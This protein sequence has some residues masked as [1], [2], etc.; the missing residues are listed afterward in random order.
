MTYQTNKFI[1]RRRSSSQDGVTI[2]LAIL[3]LSS[4]LAIT[5]SL[6]S[7]LFIE[8]RSSTDLVKS[9]GS[10]Y[11]SSAVA[12]EAVYS[13]KRGVCPSDNQNCFDFV[14]NFSSNSTL[15]TQPAFSSTSTPVIQEKIPRYTSFTNTKNIYDF[16]GTLATQ[17]GCG[18]GR[19]QIVFNDI[20]NNSSAFVYLCEFS[21]TMSYGSAPCSDPYNTLYFTSQHK[22]QLSASN[23]QVVWDLNTSM[24]QALYIYNPSSADAYVTITT[25]DTNMSTL[26]GLPFV[27][28]TAVDISTQNGQLGRKV[29][30]IVPK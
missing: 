30:V 5:F 25:Y 28:K 26:K 24:Q 6:S 15:T 29:R 4:I 16:C 9:E 7:I 1:F 14:S 12:E 19:V 18:Y 22:T 10:L 3:I 23:G 20:G 13:V 11:G 2:L 8:L 17:S 21:P 27:G